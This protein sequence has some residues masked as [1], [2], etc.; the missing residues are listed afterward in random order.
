MDQG[1]LEVIGFLAVAVVGPVVAVLRMVRRMTSPGQ[2]FAV[3]W[4]SIWSLSTVAAAAYGVLLR[5]TLR[6][7]EMNWTALAQALPDELVRH[8]PA[9]RCYQS[10]GLVFV[11][12]VTPSS[13]YNRQGHVLLRNWAAEAGWD[14]VAAGDRECGSEAD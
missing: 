11:P 7:P 4:L 8:V 13:R 10:L 2:V 6:K 12:N 9:K 1:Q 5:L 14:A 3:T